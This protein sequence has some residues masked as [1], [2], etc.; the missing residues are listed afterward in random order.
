MAAT[1]LS[2]TQIIAPFDGVVLSKNIEIGQLVSPGMPLFSV[3]N[4]SSYKIKL[5]VNGD[6]IS[7]FE[8]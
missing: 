1:Q 3:G 2:N 6:Q 5:D 4:T 8:T 7:S